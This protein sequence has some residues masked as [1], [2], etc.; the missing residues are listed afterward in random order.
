MSL[1]FLFRINL[2]KVY[3]IRQ[4]NFFVPYYRHGVNIIRF[5]THTF[6]LVYHILSLWSIIKYSFIVIF[7][8]IGAIWKNNWNYTL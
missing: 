2:C 7:L 6:G 8:L 3:E 5:T 1:N 4:S